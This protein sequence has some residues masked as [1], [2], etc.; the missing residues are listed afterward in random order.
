MKGFLK[1]FFASLL[2]LIAFSL[3]GIIIVVWMAGNA[4]SDDKADVG[5]NA[6]LVLDLSASFPE[7]T[8]D[9]TLNAL[10]DS[11]AEASIPGL[12][13]AIRLIQHAK[14]DSAVKGIYI[15]ASY[16]NNG[17]GA[18]EELR[19]AIVDFKKSGK[20]VIAYGEVLTQKAYLVASAADK[21][22]CHPK[23]GLDW[24]GYSTQLIFFKNLLD[25]LQIQP[26]IFY[27]GKYK[28]ATEPFRVT[29][30][31]SANREQTSV[32]LGDLYGSFLLHIAE[33]RKLDTASLHRLASDGAI[34]T[35]SDAVN[36]KLIDAARYDD[37]VKAEIFSRLKTKEI[38]K[39]N[40]VSLSK[41][42]KSV[43][44]N[45]GSF[46]TRVA[47]IFAEGDIVDGKGDEGQ[48]GSEPFRNLFR[49]ARFDKNIKAV[50]LRVNSPGGSALASDVI[51][52]EIMLTRKEKPVV[53]SMGD[54]AASGGYYIA[55][56]GDSVFADANTITGSIGVFTMMVNMKEF[57]KNKL[58]ITFDGVATSPYANTGSATR[59]LTDA[60]RRFLQ[61]DVDS[62]YMSFKERVASGRKRSVTYIDSIAQGRVWTGK[63]AIEIGLVDRIGT[64]QD[65]ITCAVRMAKIKDYRIKEFPERKSLIDQLMGGGATKSVKAKAI[66]EEI[67]EEQFMLFQQ[68]KKVKGWFDIP[69]ARLPF[70]LRVN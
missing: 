27:A 59:P 20:F 1:I 26:E 30:M 36:F 5:S 31:T 37:E 54:V 13:Q 47:L 44:L 49:K 61:A 64:L 67:G 4:V 34:R 65:A 33:A 42:A 45:K 70:E 62:V 50:V 40:F 11:E 41:Y 10:F 56:G 69:Q 25:K 48:I 15:K 3:I 2:A 16:N 58:G 19:N 23:G 12:Y 43:N 22:Y 9:N 53:V 29:E 14:S 57:F 17:S 18:N 6:V 24:S 21:V 52:R 46:D 8:K 66:R 39:L 60:E 32:W 68:M 55:C 63:R 35:A 51:W 28:S 38:E 7:Q